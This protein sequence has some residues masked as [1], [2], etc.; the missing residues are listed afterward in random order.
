MIAVM[1]VYYH[2]MAL[3]FNH[4]QSSHL[5]SYQIEMIAFVT[6][7]FDSYIIPLQSRICWFLSVILI[8]SLGLPWKAICTWILE[9]VVDSVGEVT[10]GSNLDT[11]GGSIVELSRPP[12][13]PRQE[14]PVLPHQLLPVH[15]LLLLKAEP[16]GGVV[17]GVGVGEVGREGERGGQEQSRQQQQEKQHLGQILDF[18]AARFEIWHLELVETTITCSVIHWLENNWRVSDPK[19]VWTLSMRPWKHETKHDM[20]EHEV[21]RLDS[22]EISPPL[23]GFYVSRRDCRGWGPGVLWGREG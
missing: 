17:H 7:T 3:P 1:S 10:G 13:P 11:V 6:V 16:D 19:E 15:C 23:W 21:A 8:Y 2:L 4:N 9:A 20:M 14:H 5:V 18:A 22:V 12:P